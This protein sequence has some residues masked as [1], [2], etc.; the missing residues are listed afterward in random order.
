LVVRVPTDMTVRMYFHQEKFELV[1]SCIYQPA[2]P[3][4]CADNSKLLR[5]GIYSSLRV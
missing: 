2:N 3:T 4:I 5:T 1:R